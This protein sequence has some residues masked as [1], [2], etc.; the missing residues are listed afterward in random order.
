MTLRRARLLLALLAAAATAQSL[1]PPPGAVEKVNKIFAQFARIDGPGC[2][3]GVGQEGQQVLVASYGMADLEHSVSLTPASVFEPGSVT[4]QFTAAAVLLLAQDGKLSLDDP[5]RKYF[6]ELPD[7]ANTITIRHLLNH[8]SGL[9]D[10]GEV[11]AVGGWPRGTRANSNANV[12]DI[13]IRQ[14]ALNYPPGA[15]WSYTNTGYNLLAMLVGRVSGKSLAE[16]TRERIFLPLGMTSTEWRDD[17][18][19]IVHNRAMA[20]AQSGGIVRLDM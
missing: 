6:P 14:K 11:A 16:F 4:K 2:A 20:Y 5:A 18:Q 3:V 13:T 1:A 19:R 8:T 7:H 15:E 17:Y 9:R 12:L 10:W